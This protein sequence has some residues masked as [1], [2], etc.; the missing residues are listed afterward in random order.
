MRN[1][2]KEWV[3]PYPYFVKQNEL[4]R[5]E[6][7]SV[8]GET[9]EVELK[10]SR[11]A[12]VITKM[13]KHIERNEIHYEV[14]W[15]NKGDS[16][17][18]TVSA[19][20]LASKRELLK[21]ADMGLGCNDSNS[22]HFVEYFD[23]FIGHNEIPKVEMTDRLG[24]I[25]NK[26]IHPIT[27]EDIHVMAKDSGESQLLES[28][29]TKGTAKSW[30]DNVFNLI[31]N[32]PKAV[33]PVVSSFAS[34]ILHEEELKPIVIDVSGTSSTGKSG[35]LRLCASV[36]GEPEKYIGTFN[37][38]L[39]AIER[40]STF[41]NSFPQILDDSN[42]A[43]DS[44]FIQPM[45]YQYV[46]TTGKQR[47]SLAGSQHTDS[48]TSLMI[49]SGENEITTYANA[50]GVPARVISISNFSFANEGK[51]FLGNV[52]GSCKE[53]FGAIGIE[54][55]RRWREKRDELLKELPIYERAFLEIS[56]NDITKRLSRHYAFIVFTGKILNELFKSE[57]LEIDLEEL[58]NLYVEMSKSNKSLDLPLVE[59]QSALEDMDANRNKLYADYEPN[60]SI[61]G[62]Y[63]NGDFYFSPAYLK[64]RL[65]VN[66]KQIRYLWMKRGFT[67]IFSNRGIEVDYKV[68]KKNKR[69]FR[70]V[71]VNKEIIEKLDFDFS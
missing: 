4:Y 46:N 24:Q 56:N 19:G 6:S 35:L 33:F 11:N 3:I 41:L 36:W 68:I 37:T 52:Y 71:L 60:G 38:T 29:Q 8:K 50:Q 5:I 39:V 30:I 64:E 21:M 31:K 53:N 54:F 14:T 58:K 16:Y 62:F 43:N 32:H 57:R 67:G 66:E 42:G 9:Q 7:K 13:Y 17:T 12:P 28:F 69:A 48:W 61:N 44:K 22:K 65:G 25:K 45:I 18:E 20:V 49:T 55:L 51:E 1:E 40:R 2:N 23:L 47:G 10:V 59:L 63:H 70:A 15:E 26:F 34:V 27:S